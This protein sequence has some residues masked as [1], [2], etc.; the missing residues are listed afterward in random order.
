MEDNLL[1][2]ILVMCGALLSA[3]GLSYLITFLLIK[4]TSKLVFALP[5]L[6]FLVS[7]YFWVAALLSSD[8]LVLGYLVVAIISVIALLGS[9]GSSLLIYFKKIKIRNKDFS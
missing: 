5:I 1:N 4:I 8:W 3:F 2:Q 6:V 7:I 9:L